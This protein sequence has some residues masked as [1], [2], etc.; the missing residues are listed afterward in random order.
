[1]SHVKETV[2]PMMYSPLLCPVEFTCPLVGVGF[3][4]VAEIFILLIKI[5]QAGLIVYFIG[6]L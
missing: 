5:F 6:E 3:A 1:M 4:H 2:V